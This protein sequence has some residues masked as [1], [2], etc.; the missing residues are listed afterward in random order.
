MNCRNVSLMPW[1]S[2]AGKRLSEPS[3]RLR[4]MWHELPS[5]SSNFGMKVSA[6]PCRNAISLAPLR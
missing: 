4:W 2:A 5:R 1:P 6:L 3:Q